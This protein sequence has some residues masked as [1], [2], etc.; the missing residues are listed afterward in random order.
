M[1]SPAVSVVLLLAINS[2][3]AGCNFGCPRGSCCTSYGSC[4]SC[5][6]GWP[7]LV[8]PNAGRCLST[9]CPAGMCCSRYGYCGST[10]AYCGNIGWHGFGNCALTGCGAGLCCSTYGY[11][12]NSVAACPWYRKSSNVIDVPSLDGVLHSGLAKLY[13]VNSEYVYTACGFNYTTSGNVASLNYAQFD[14]F[15]VNGIPSTNPSCNKKA[16]VTGPGNTKITVT[17]VDRCPPEANCNK[18]DIGLSLPAFKALTGNDEGPVKIYDSRNNMIQPQIY[19]LQN[20]LIPPY[21]HDSH[22]NMIQPQIYDSQN[23]MIQPQAYDSHNNMIQPQ[24]YDS[25]NGMIQPQTYDLQN[26]MIPPQGQHTF[27]V[28]RKNSSINAAEQEERSIVPLEMQDELKIN[29]ET[30]IMHYYVTHEPMRRETPIGNT[31]SGTERSVPLNLGECKRIAKD[32][33]T[34]R[35]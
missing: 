23:G 35:R 10:P 24:I 22:N 21:I 17:I 26:G 9:G 14:P 25:Q 34:R 31:Y 13:E 2:I 5:G 29:P 6:Y 27:V 11:C 16:L 15:T 1:M 20:G 8:D 33:L 28:S 4:G 30:P 19:D 18:G 32:S 12:G 3:D 7:N